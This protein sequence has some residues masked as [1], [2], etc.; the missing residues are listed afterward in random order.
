MMH[1]VRRGLTVLEVTVAASLMAALA[2]LAVPAFSGIGEGGDGQAKATVSAVLDAQLL[3]FQQ[4]GSFTGD[5]AVINSLLPR[6]TVTDRESGSGASGSSDVAS[7]AVED[8]AV[9][10]AARTGTQGCWFARANSTK[11]IWAFGDS[12]YNCSGAEALLVAVESDDAPGAG[13][14]PSNAIA[15][16][17]RG[18]QGT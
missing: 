3:V 7:I 4:N 18:N 17:S 2:V 16:P 12:S 9:G 14:G 5:A 15:L 6:L 11:T 1:R 10:V 13:D 8:G